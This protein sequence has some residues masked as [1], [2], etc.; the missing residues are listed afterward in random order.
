[1][2]T[3]KQ[4]LENINIAGTV[5]IDE[6]MSCHTTFEVGGPADLLVKPETEDDVATI[7]TAAHKTGFPLFVLGGGAN[8]LVSDAGIRGVVLDLTPLGELHHEGARLIC[9]AGAE[10]TAVTAY[11]AENGL[12]GI[13]FL[14]SMPGTIGGAVWMNARCYG[15]SIADILAEVRG[16]TPEGRRFA[17][18]PKE[19]DFEYKKSPFQERRDVITACDFHLH[20]EDPAEVWERMV[21]YYRD[22]ERK[23]H[24]SAPSAGSIFKNNRSFGRPSGA[25]IDSLGL[26]GTQIGGARISDRHANIIVNTGNASAWDIRRLMEYV[27]QEVRLRLGYELEQEVLYVGEWV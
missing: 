17:Y 22:R 1:M 12:G 20:R 5:L 3:V 10:V 27:Q 19:Q 18:Q 6:P 7:L 16:V 15:S 26:R 2:S 23:G 4:Y 8:I 21:G 9:G 25:I 24:F 13:D 14:H 11:A